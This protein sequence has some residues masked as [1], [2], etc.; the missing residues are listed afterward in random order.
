M[1]S[2][3]KSYDSDGNALAGGDNWLS[4]FK[5]NEINRILQERAAA[6]QEPTRTIPATT[7]EISTEDLNNTQ[8]SNLSEN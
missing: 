2:L 7:P 4:D 5:S 3:A 1:Y 8:S 6:N